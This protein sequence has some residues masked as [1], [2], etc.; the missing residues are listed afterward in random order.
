M[1]SPR[2][3]V[4]GVSFLGRKDSGRRDTIAPARDPES[5]SQRRGSGGGYGITGR[6][7]TRTGRVDT[8]GRGTE[9]LHRPT[10]RSVGG[11]RR[12]GR[13]GRRSRGRTA[14]ATTRSRRRAL[15]GATLIPSPRTAD[16]A[17]SP[18]RASLGTPR[19][20]Q[21][22]GRPIGG[23]TGIPIGTVPGP[24][25]PMAAAGTRRSVSRGRTSVAGPR[26]AGVQALGTVMDPGAGSPSRGIRGCSI[27]GP[28]GWDP[29]GD[30][31]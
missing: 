27:P 18:Q 30:W 21:S 13:P 12:D 6:C 4:P 7:R 3:N 24:G 10:K 9:G 22:A 23:A 16:G 5:G 20:M 2:P 25:V 29:T 31:A 8:G 28:S 1:P 17:V 19:G 14:I 11:S 15:R 26:I